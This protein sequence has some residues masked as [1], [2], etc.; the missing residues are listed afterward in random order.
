MS[1]SLTDAQAREKFGSIDVKLH[2]LRYTK[3]PQK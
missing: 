1:L 2:Y 3:A